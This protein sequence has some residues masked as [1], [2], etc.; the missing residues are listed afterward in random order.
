MNGK[1][2]FL[3]PTV[4]FDMKCIMKIVLKL[5]QYPAKL[6]ELMV[7]EIEG[8]KCHI[9]HFCC[10]RCRH[11]VEFSLQTAWILSAY[12]ADVLKPNWKN[13]QGIKLKNMI[14]NEELRCLT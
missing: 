1:Y 6:R 11:S 9:Q 2:Y 8:T 5:L 14:L 13:S 3:K 10:C 12:S 4:N 7:R